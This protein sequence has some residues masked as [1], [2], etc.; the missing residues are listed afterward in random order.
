MLNDLDLEELEKRYLDYI[1]TFLRQ[2][3][4]RSHKW[5]KLKNKNI[6]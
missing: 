2:G 3:S 1:V 4:K 6:K 5:I